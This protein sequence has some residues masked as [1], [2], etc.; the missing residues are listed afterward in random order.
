MD[1]PLC[2]AISNEN[3][4]AFHLL[5]EKGAILARAVPLNYLLRKAAGYWALQPKAVD[6]RKTDAQ[7]DFASLAHQA[8]QGLFNEDASTSSPLEDLNLS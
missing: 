1:T 4:Q 3:W 5:L 8:L 7:L 6:T 2:L